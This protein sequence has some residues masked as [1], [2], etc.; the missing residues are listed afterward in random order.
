VDP[1]RLLTG[2]AAGARLAAACVLVGLLALSH[3]APTQATGVRLVSHGPRTEPVIAL[4]FDD[5]VSP[6]NCRRILAI[7]VEQHVPATFFPLAEAMSLDPA[8]WRLVGEVG[9]P[10]GDHTYSHPQMPSLS[11]AAQ[12]GE[13]DRGRRVAERILGRPLLR[14]FRPPYGAYNTATLSAAARAGFGTVLLWDVTD[15]STSPTASLAKMRSSAEQGTN[16]SVVL[17][18]CG[19][20][21]TPYLLPDVIASY[22]ARG[23][24]FVTVAQLLGVPWSPGATRVVTPTEIL[25]GLTPLPSSAMGGPIT[26]PHGYVPARGSAPTTT[27][28]ATTAPLAVAHATPAATSMLPPLDTRI[29][30]GA[31][32]SPPIPPTSTSAATDPEAFAD[33]RAFG[34]LAGVAIVVGAVASVALLRRFARR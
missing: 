25:H 18:H 12:F 19:P 27:V 22:R 3:S 5:G 1:H 24:R 8:F 17:M 30:T 2:R 28:A 11:L 34:A 20:N 7:L 15:R 14:V 21:V 33:D 9:D 6:S 26:G 23:F 29:T 4:T 32:G 10:V 16:G 13:I 31:T